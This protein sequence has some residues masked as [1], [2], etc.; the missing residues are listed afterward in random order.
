M[1][2]CIL[3]TAG[4]MKFTV[5]RNDIAVA[6]THAVHGI[7]N[8]PVTPIRAGMVIETREGNVLFSG[9]D[10]DV[11]FDATAVGQTD[12]DEKIV[13]PGKLFA[14]VIRTLP[15]QP[16]S[17]STDHDKAVLTCGRVEFRFP[18]YKE[19][20][21]DL[22]DNAGGSGAIEGDVFIDMVRRV[23]PACAKTDT[24]PA[25]SAVLFEP[26]GDTLWMAAT[27]RYRLA[28]VHS[29]WTPYGQCESALVPAWA[30]ERFT[31]SVSGTVELGWD[32][33]VV[34]LSSCN[35]QVTS[36]VMQG[37]FPKWRGL[38]P[39]EPPTVQ[40]SAPDL[41]G[42]LKRSQLACEQDSPV[43]LTFTSGRLRVEAGYGNHAEDVLDATYQG[44]EF[45]ALFGVGRLVDGL[46]GCADTVLFRFTEPL[47]PVHMQADNYFYTVLPRRRI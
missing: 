6:V 5:P 11:N 21:P 32:E 7:P 31:R 28:A 30:L 18:V 10:G 27:D 44:D 20:Y 43:E 29:A 41:L 2:S 26:T 33:R 3:W 46:A 35:L 34:T 4:D 12:N 42:A 36:R 45:Q 17:L 15:D 40:V 38:L 9:S 25:L 14:D 37:E 13:V 16:V 8:N 22:P 47:K 1:G 19:K 39:P 23:I 24:N